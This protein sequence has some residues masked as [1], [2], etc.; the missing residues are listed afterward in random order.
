M[1]DTA[2][3]EKYR[4]ITKSFYTNIDGVVFVYDITNQD[5][6]DNLESWIKEFKDSNSGLAQILILGNKKDLIDQRVISSSQGLEL[7]QN[8]KALFQETT[9]KYKESIK[10]ALNLLVECNL[11]RVFEDREH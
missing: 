2:G 4:A 5:S 10:G 9:I 3:Q 11:K 1:W 6:F 7:A 8:H